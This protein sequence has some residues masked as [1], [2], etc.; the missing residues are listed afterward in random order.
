MGM[1]SWFGMEEREDFNKPLKQ[2][3]SCLLL[4][5]AI[6]GAVKTWTFDKLTTFPSA[7]EKQAAKINGSNLKIF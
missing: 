6:S 7:C 4:G 1:K 5:V 2:C 3:A